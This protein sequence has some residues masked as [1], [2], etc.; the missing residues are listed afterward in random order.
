[1]TL[2]DDLAHQY[3]DEMDAF[4]EEQRMTYI[5]FAERLAQEKG[6]HQGIEQGIERGVE[7]GLHAGRIQ[8]I[9]RQL[10]RLFGALDEDDLTAIQALTVPQLD[11]LSEDLLDFTQLADLSAWL[12]Q[13][14]AA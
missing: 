14:P 12:Q 8:S 2:P 4:E 13:P 11:R 3:V 9:T 10:R 6:F 1:M 5:S 7:Q